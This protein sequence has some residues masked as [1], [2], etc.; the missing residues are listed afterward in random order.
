MA[1]TKIHDLTGGTAAATD[2]VPVA[3]T[4]FASGDNRKLALS[5]LDTYFSA[6]TK[7]LTNKTLNA[8]VGKGTW[9]AS[10]TW[11]LP[12]LTLGGTIS[13]GANQLNNVRIGASTPLQGS[14]TTLSTTG[15][16]SAG[17]VINVD[18]AANVIAFSARNSALADTGFVDFRFGKANASN[19]EAIYRW[20]YNAG[21]GS[22]W[23]L[24][25]FDGSIQLTATH[26]GGIQVGSVGSGDK[27][28]NT[29]R[30]TGDIYTGTATFILRNTATITGAS[31]GNVPTLTAGPVTGNPTK[32]L[33][34]D[35]N[36]TTRYIP[37]W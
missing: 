29:L 16:F 1:D 33:P 4:P 10:G 22:T 6:T 9:T 37:S 36:G 23:Q 19:Q 25:S 15:T 5:D 12:A 31:T 11:T 34:Y 7:E 24:L 26:G 20:T 13:G 27:G 18:T 21:G 35:D 30:V 2:E 3:I 8:S 17:G 14:F 28:A 32:W